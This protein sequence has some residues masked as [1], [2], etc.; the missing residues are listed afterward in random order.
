MNDIL[1]SNLF[2]ALVGAICGGILTTIGTMMTF[3]IKRIGR[4]VIFNN[5][6]HIEY[7]TQD[8]SYG[9]DIE[10]DDLVEADR[11]LISIN[12]SI[13]NQKEVPKTLGDF[14][15]EIQFSG[16]KI[17][18]PVKEIHLQDIGESTFPFESE[19]PVLTIPPK[20]TKQIIGKSILELDCIADS[21]KKVFLL[22][23]FP[24]KNK[25][26]KKII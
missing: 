6:S 12:L 9:I 22:A 24:N 11:V 3:I 26:R 4:L 16:E 17:I 10:A 7:I 18:I 23:K 21:I 2:A 14:N 8:S 25:F 5:K 20:E 13:Y 19:V 15:I 1:E